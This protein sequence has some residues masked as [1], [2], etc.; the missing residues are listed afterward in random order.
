LRLPSPPGIK[1]NVAFAL[2]LSQRK[3]FVGSEEK[4]TPFSFTFTEIT[5]EK[6]EF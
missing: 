5:C 2:L 3:V 1:I 6:D 4:K